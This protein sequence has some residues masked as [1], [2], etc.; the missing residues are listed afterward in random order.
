[1]SSLD[2]ALSLFASQDEPEKIPDPASHDDVKKLVHEMAW[3]SEGDTLKV[4]IHLVR[5]LWRLE[6]GLMIRDA[7]HEALDER[8]LFDIEI[9]VLPKF[10]DINN[11]TQTSYHGRVELG[12][13]RPQRY[14]NGS[15]VNEP[16]PQLRSSK[17][18]PSAEQAAE[19]LFFEDGYVPVTSRYAPRTHQQL[20]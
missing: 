4:T 2:S 15:W 6:Y 10:I 13:S 5:N 14:N 1:M 19:D 16:T 11:E 12:W 7:I 3:L 17:P 18:S 20:L 9:Q 8:G